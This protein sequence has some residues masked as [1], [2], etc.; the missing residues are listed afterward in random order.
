MKSRITIMVLTVVLFCLTPVSWGQFKIGK[1]ALGGGGKV[2]VDDVLKR[3]ERVKTDFEGAT[4]C[5]SQGRDIIFDLSATNEK[6]RQLQ[7]KEA[8]LAAAQ[9]DKDRERITIEIEEMKDEEIKRAQRSG[10]LENKRLTKEQSK[11]VGKLIFNLGLAIKLDRSAVKNGPKIISD[12]EKAIKGARKNAFQW[13]KI[14]TRA[15]KLTQ[16]ISKDIPGILKEAPH[17]IETLSALLEASNTLKRNNEIV[18][19][20]EPEEGDEF[21]E[22]EYTPAPIVVEKP[23]ECRFTSFF[24]GGSTDFDPAFTAM[25]QSGDFSVEAEGWVQSALDSVPQLNFVPLDRSI[26]GLDEVSARVEPEVLFMRGLVTRADI[27]K[28]EKFA[29]EEYVFS[30]NATLEFFDLVSGEVFYTRTLTGQFF[31]ERAKGSE[32]S[33]GDKQDYFKRCLKGTVEEICQRIG[34]DY[35]PGV[36][37]GHIAAMPDTS[38]AALDIGRQ[39]GVYQGMTFY[40]YSDPT[41]SP[42]GLLKAGSPQ[43]N[44]CRG[45]IV[46]CQEGSPERGWTVRSFGINKLN[47]QKGR[48]RYMVAEFSPAVSEDLPPDFRLDPQ[49]LGQW[50]H[51]GLSS[52]TELFLLAPLL[53]KLDSSGTVQVQGALADAQ[54]KY[55]IFGG[56][57]QSTA[58][59]SRAFPDVLIKGVVTHA[60]IQTFITPGAENKVLE[61]GVS[62]EFYDRRTRDFLYA[63]QR[64]GRKLEKIVTDGEKVYRALELEASFR[65]LCKDVIRR[66]AAKIGKEYKPIPLHGEVVS[67]EADGKSFTIGFSQMGAGVGDLF[68]LMTETETIRAISGEELGA[69]VKNYGIAKLTESKRDN[70]FKAMVLVSDGITMVEAG[71]IL[72]TEGRESGGK[73]GRLCQV[74]GWQA[75]GNVT[76]E[77]DYSTARLTEWLHD[78]LLTTGEYRLLPPNFREGSMGMVEV[79]LSLGQFESRDI[80]EIIYQGVRVP[81]IVVSGELVQADM[82]RKTGEFKD[83]LTLKS[84]V[85]VIFSTAEGDTLYSNRLSASKKIEQVKSRGQ[86]VVGTEDLSPEFDNLTKETIEKLVK[87]IG[88]EYAP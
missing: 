26:S 33:M 5:L 11:H 59:G 50:L 10:D 82:S 48:V 24:I 49:T 12:G 44:I 76:K 31:T 53:T 32:I 41:E 68:K 14:A 16:A 65:D 4:R 62:I 85:E 25:S 30:T 37:E 57:A 81:E 64:S 39:D 45:S 23:V 80:G 84:G 83:I 47:Q 75:K 29:T 79:G 66:A 2:D 8:E 69:L 6:K 78:A 72:L 73:T 51:D 71:D 61:V 20:G 54:L 3:V 46:F 86:T 88:E 34:K 17:Q 28:V 36:L 22:I 27:K 21:V 19:L 67:V 18:D 70:E 87:K 1:G 74:I 52:R 38:A 55:S 56:L 42:V 15:K 77:Y 7:T 43:E 9:S 40:I 60:G 58:M 35:Q 13:V 63:S